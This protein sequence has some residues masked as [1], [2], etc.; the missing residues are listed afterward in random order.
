MLD[1]LTAEQ[2]FERIT[3]AAEGIVPVRHMVEDEQAADEAGIV[4]R[5]RSFGG[6]HPF[7]QTT[8]GVQDGLRIRMCL[9]LFHRNVRQTLR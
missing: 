3:D 9:K 8:P 1:Q 4:V 7:R 2:L 6:I 5:G